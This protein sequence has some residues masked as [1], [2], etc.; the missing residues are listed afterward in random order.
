MD[1]Q[2][3]QREAFCAD[4]GEGWTEL[5]SSLPVWLK[6][7]PTVLTPAN[8][9]AKSVRGCSPQSYAF[10][11]AKQLK[12]KNIGPVLHF[13]GARADQTPLRIGPAQLIVFADGVSRM[14]L[15]MGPQC[16]LR[17]RGDDIADHDAAETGN[18][19]R[20]EAP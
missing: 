18:G 17:Q 4:K 2:I 9:S 11:I 7:M 1:V 16:D 20:Q 6:C 12:G 8:L 13:R 19:W 5:F 15:F 10:R 14:A 3:H